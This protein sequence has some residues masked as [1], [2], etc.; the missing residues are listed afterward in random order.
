MR[1]RSFG[2]A[3]CNVAVSVG[4]LP[5]NLFLLYYLTEIL[6]VRATLAGLA[7]ALPKVWDALIDPMLGGWIDR[8]AL[9]RN[10]S[11]VERVFVVGNS[12]SIR[13]INSPVT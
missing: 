3:L 5:I 4:S 6:G 11:R 12:S 8:L 10:A 9:G 13:S 1:L 2:Y 7:V